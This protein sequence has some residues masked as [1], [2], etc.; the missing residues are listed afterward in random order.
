MKKTIYKRIVFQPNSMIQYYCQFMSEIYVF[1]EAMVDLVNL[2][3]GMPM[4]ILV[5][6]Q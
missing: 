4:D 5:N 1:R 3:Y 6:K 2:I